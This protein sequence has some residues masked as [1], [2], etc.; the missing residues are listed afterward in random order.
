MDIIILVRVRVCGGE[1][2]QLGVEIYGF[3]SKNIG[4]IRENYKRKCN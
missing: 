4:E 3:Y 2:P 1:T